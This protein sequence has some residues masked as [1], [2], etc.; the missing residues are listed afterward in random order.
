MTF[1]ES[2]LGTI[3]TDLLTR[4]APIAPVTIAET[5]TIREAEHEG[6]TDER[7]TLRIAQWAKA[8]GAEFHSIDLSARHIEI[9]AAVLDAH[10]LTAYFHHGDGAAE[11]AT[12]DD[13]SLDFVLLDSDSDP[14][15]IAREWREVR[16]KMKPTSIIVIDDCYGR[17]V[18]NGVDKGALVKKYA[19]GC[20][21][22]NQ[23]YVIGNGAAEKIVKEYAGE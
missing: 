20:A 14:F 7:S 6:A 11:L 18:Y 17:S 5:G 1:P 19:A 23:C 2:T 9:A 8:N 15:V 3:C 10:K 13:A 21:V 22:R 4:L 12:F 16:T